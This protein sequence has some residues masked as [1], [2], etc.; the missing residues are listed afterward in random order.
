M[1]LDSI[2][3]EMQCTD[4]NSDSNLESLSGKD[5]ALVTVSIENGNN[6]EVCNPVM[7]DTDASLSCSNHSITVHHSSSI[8]NFSSTIE[9]ENDVKLGMCDMYTN[10]EIL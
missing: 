9:K 6:E 4:Y 2:E 8:S 3:I 1:E 7:E 10:T 5:P